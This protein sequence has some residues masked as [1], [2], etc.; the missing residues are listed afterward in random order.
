[1]IIKTQKT[2]KTVTTISFSAVL[3]NDKGVQF[4]TMSGKIDA[5][6]PFG[7]TAL[8]VHNQAVFAE[9][10]EAAKTAFAEFQAAVNATV[11]TVEPSVIVTEG[12]D[13]S[14]SM[15]DGGL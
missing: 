14:D 7:T 8:T 13:V 9:H 5:A 1:M 2:T 11:G 3:K 4:A 10:E 6:R 15:D 12:D